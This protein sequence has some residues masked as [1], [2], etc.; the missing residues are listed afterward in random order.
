[1]W[2]KQRQGILERPHQSRPM[3]TPD[4]ELGRRGEQRGGIANGRSERAAPPEGNK[5]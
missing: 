5:F 4:E 3:A 1:M 2:N